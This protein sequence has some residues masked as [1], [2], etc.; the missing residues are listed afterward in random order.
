MEKSFKQHMARHDVS[1]GEFECEICGFRFKNRRRVLAHAREYHVF[2]Y[3]CKICK[4]TYKNPHWARFHYKMH[5]GEKPTCKQCGEQ[6]AHPSVLQL[7]VRKE[8]GSARCPICNIVCAKAASVQQ[9]IA[10]VHKVQQVCCEKCDVRFESQEA[11]TRHLEDST[12]KTCSKDKKPCGTCGDSFSTEESFEKHKQFCTPPPPPKKDYKCQQCFRPFASAQ[13]L[14]NH[15][16]YYHKRDPV[17]NKCMEPGMKKRGR[18]K[19]SKVDKTAPPKTNYGY[20]TLMCEICG[21]NNFKFKSAL[22]VH[23]ST[24][25]R[26][27]PFK[28]DVCDKSFKL[29]MHLKLHM[30]VHTGEK[31]YECTVCAKKFRQHAHLAQHMVLHTNEM[32]F[33]CEL[34]GKRF[35]F[36]GSHWQHMRAHEGIHRA[37]ANPRSKYSYNIAE[38]TFDSL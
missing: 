35:R 29:Q 32:P 12:D 31:R 38:D 3:T 13:S 26:E 34:C 7:H 20:P 14:R 5:Q 18:K 2:N 33:S 16:N 4:K 15:M 25:S 27:R 30:A 8:H 9:H 1:R 10:L 36:Q 23:Q 24:H 28:C 11:L 37:R 19:G 22:R 21:K 6:F 17:T